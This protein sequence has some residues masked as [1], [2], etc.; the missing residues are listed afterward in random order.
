VDWYLGVRA[1][2]MRT[3]PGD[4]SF[5]GGRELSTSVSNCL[6]FALAIALAGFSQRSR[7]V[8]FVPPFCPHRDCPRHR[9]DDPTAFSFVRHGSYKRKGDLRVVPRF[10][11]STCRGTLSEQTFSTTYY[12]KC[13]ELLPPV[14][15]GLEAGSAHRQLARSLGCAPS[16]VTRLSERLGRHAML[17]HAL[18]LERLE[19]IQE[20]VI[21]DHFETFAASQEQALGI[22]TAVGQ[23]S[24]F[25]YEL[26]YVLHRRGGRRTPAQQARQIGPVPRGKG[27]GHAF[28]STLDRLEGKVAPAR[29]LTLV[30]DDHPGYRLAPRHA[31]K[32]DHQVFANPNRAYKGAPRSPEAIVRDWQMFATDQLHGLLRHSLAHHRRETIAFGR[33]HNAVLERVAL[34]AVWRNFIKMRSERKPRDT[35]AMR[36]GL[37]DRPWSWSHALARRLFPSRVRLPATWQALYRREL[38]TAGLAPQRRHARV[39]AF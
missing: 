19:Q 2:R 26:D 18:A 33:R 10:R 3:T 16:T 11:C 31:S 38:L 7:G 20:P 21:Y 24:W 34:M 28:R 30:T 13:P 15:A 17:L 9:R 22:G 5:A 6:E 1:V 29:R 4:N 14:A 27:Y 35:P 36:V 8:D 37:T 39:H 12:L 25:I 23:S 32:V